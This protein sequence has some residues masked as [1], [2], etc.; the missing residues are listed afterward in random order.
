M[1]LS[2]CISSVDEFRSRD[3]LGP[4]DIRLKG[5]NSG[6]EAVDENGRPDLGMRFSAPALA[7]ALEIIDQDCIASLVLFSYCE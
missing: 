3:W 1:R 7:V 4:A 2:I 5:K 6:G